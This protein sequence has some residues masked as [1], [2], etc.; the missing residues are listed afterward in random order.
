MGATATTHVA[1][2]GKPRSL[3]HIGRTYT[4]CN[5]W[6]VDLHVRVPGAAFGRAFIP[7]NVTCPHC[8]RRVRYL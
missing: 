8:W 7:Q 1:M 2:L 3:Q 5:R 6:V 4:L